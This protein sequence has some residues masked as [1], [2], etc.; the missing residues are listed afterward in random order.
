MAEAYRGL[1]VRDFEELRLPESEGP[2]VERLAEGLRELWERYNPGESQRRRES[3][4]E[5][6][7]AL[8]KLGRDVSAEDLDAVASVLP[9]LSGARLRR[10]GASAEEVRQGTRLVELWRV[11]RARVPRRPTVRVEQARRSCPWAV[12]EYEGALW[13]D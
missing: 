11:F 4:R 3:L 7:V 12:E 8:G 10:L 13:D 1:A 5:A 9:A 6:L 2:A